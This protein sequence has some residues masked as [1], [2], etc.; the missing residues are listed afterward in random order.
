M[1]YH[2]SCSHCP[3][4]KYQHQYAAVL[5]HL[6]DTKISFLLFL[7]SFIFLTFLKLSYSSLIALTQITL[8][9]MN[10]FTSLCKILLSS[11]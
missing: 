10:H 5:M 7:F 2:Q 6:S 8:A 4:S 11:Y 9:H 1:K 3:Y